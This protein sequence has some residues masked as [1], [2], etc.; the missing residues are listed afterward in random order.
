MPSSPWQR[1]L[2]LSQRWQSTAS[3]MVG[4][5]RQAG[6]PRERFERRFTTEVALPT[7]KQDNDF[8]EVI[9]IYSGVGYPAICPGIPGAVSRGTAGRTR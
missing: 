5:T 8:Y 6:M 4:L 1:K 9:L 7:A 2:A 3:A